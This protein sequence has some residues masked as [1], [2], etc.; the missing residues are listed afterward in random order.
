MGK[1]DSHIRWNL[2]DLQFHLQKKPSAVALTLRL[3][4][5]RMIIS[6]SHGWKKAC[7]MLLYRIST[8]SPRTEVNRNPEKKEQ[9][10]RV[11]RISTQSKLY[12]RIWRSLIKYTIITFF[13]KDL[14]CHPYYNVKRLCNV[15]RPFQQYWVCLKVKV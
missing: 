10:T 4:W 7:L 15:E 8:L 12:Y 11:S 6:P 14:D 2:V 9:N 1:E 5:R 13:K 3:K